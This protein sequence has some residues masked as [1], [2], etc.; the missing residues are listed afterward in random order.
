T[1]SA[2]TKFDPSAGDVYVAALVLSRINKFDASNK[3][4]EPPSP[5]GAGSGRYSGAVVNP[6]NGTVY[7]LDAEASEIDPYDP[8]TG[9]L[10]ESASEKPFP[11]PPSDNFFIGQYTVVQIGADLA[12]NVYVPVVP[13]NKVLEYSP[14]G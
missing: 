5:F 3:L 13:G 2:C 9:E 1:G 4:L 14:A 12:G 11:V 7:V 6:A 8:M 10:V